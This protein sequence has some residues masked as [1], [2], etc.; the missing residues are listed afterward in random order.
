MGCGGVWRE[1]TRKGRG[2]RDVW[3][4]GD[5]EKRSG[6]DEGCRGVKYN[7]GKKDITWIRFLNINIL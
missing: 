3:G 6:G 5:G 2:E 1:R 4:E 7:G